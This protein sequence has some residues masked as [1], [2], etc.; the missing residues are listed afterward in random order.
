[1]CYGLVFLIFFNAEQGCLLHCCMGVRQQRHLFLAC[2]FVEFEISFFFVILYYFLLYV[3]L[4][5]NK[6]YFIRFN[7]FYST[8]YFNFLINLAQF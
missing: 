8:H 4:H 7:T 6:H 1:M 2:I 3:S 5:G